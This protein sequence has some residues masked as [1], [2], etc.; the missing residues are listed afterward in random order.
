MGKAIG[1]DTCVHVILLPANIDPGLLLFR[2]RPL[3]DELFSNWLVRLARANSLKLKTFSRKKLGLKQDFWR[4]DV[5]RHANREIAARVAK[6]TGVSEERAFATTLAAYEGTLYE[7]HTSIGPQKWLL[8]IGKGS[9][10]TLHGQQFCPRCLADDTIPYFRRKWRLSLSFACVAHHV[11]LMDA[12]PK[13]GGTVSFHRG[14]FHHLTLPETSNVTMCQHCGTD[15][16]HHIENTI[17]LPK[18]LVDFQEKLYSVLDQNLPLLGSTHPAFP[19]L[20]FDGLHLILRAL[21]S[22]GHTRR[23][24]D[25]LYVQRGKNSLATP[26]RTALIRFDELPV[27][28]RSSLLELTKHILSN[29]PQTFVGSCQAAQLSSTYFLEYRKTK[30]APYW[31]ASVV[32]GSLNGGPYRPSKEERE[33]VRRYLRRRWLP[34]GV[35]SVNRWL[36]CHATFSK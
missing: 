14:D 21:S 9:V 12:C 27:C 34:D 11:M 19:H 13:C 22:N 26:F 10:W 36:G 20:F 32:E 28:N 6:I 3:D 33:S 31:Y 25:Y 2:P 23:L 17:T 18:E 4:H 1:S 16:G 7:K 29:W 24:R 30:Q 8:P 35:N 15:L 5:D